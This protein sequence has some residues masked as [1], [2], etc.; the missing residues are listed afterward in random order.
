MPAERAKECP[1]LNRS[2]RFTLHLRCGFHCFKSPGRLLLILWITFLAACAGQPQLPYTAAIASAHPLATQ[3]GHRVLDQGGNAFDAAIATAAVL[4]VV[5]PYG[6]GL[7]GGGLWL[8][9]DAR[10]QRWTLIDARERA[11]QAAYREMYLDEE[12]Q[13]RTDKPSING[14][15]AA[16]IPGQP[17]A[18]AHLSKHYG[19]LPLS[20]VLKDAIQLAR[21]GFRTGQIYEKHASQRLAA[22]QQDPASATLFLDNGKAPV[23]GTL[24]RQPELAHTLYLLGL[25]GHAGFYQG[26]IAQALIEDV[27]RGGGIWTLQ[28]L[29]DYQVIEREPLQAT[30][31]EG[32]RVIV[33]PPPSAGGVAL[34]QMLNILHQFDW[35]HLYP[36]TRLHVIVEAMKLAYGD[37]A[38]YLGDSD[39]VDVPVDRLISEARA[40]ELAASIR[41]DQATPVETQS[42]GPDRSSHTTHLSVVDRQGNMVSATLSINLPFGA[43]FT[44]GQTGVLLNNEMD[45]F[46]LKPGLPNSYGLAGGEPN[47]IAPGKRPL[48]SMTPTI[49]E[50]PQQVA[51]LGTPGGSRIISM[52]LL[53]VLDMLS[54]QGPDSWVSLPRFHHQNQ[55]DILQFEPGAFSE[56]EQAALR[57]RGHHL[58]ELERSYGNMQ[59]IL[60]DKTTGSVQAASDP[61]GEGQAI[62]R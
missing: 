1:R 16:A 3:A 45:D 23:S 11:P 51:I 50:T 4:S 5:E 48:S 61:R 6:S 13:P 8:L 7:G 14:A 26:E 10:Q 36:K 2:L 33:P 44:S 53:G 47:S 37:R 21:H 62:A 28:D 25:K 27:R 52:V 49:V 12:G 35:R 43:A 19:R 60:W 39:Y 41:L 54:G 30:Y 38:T 42:T 32:V 46:A 29:A 15:L 18:F 59:A 57:D 22:L 20:A 34:I 40:R 17:A 31:A 58:Q 56:E 55:P 9:Y 24:I